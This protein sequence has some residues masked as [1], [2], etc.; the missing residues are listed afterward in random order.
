M[1]L[2]GLC[3]VG[4]P[5][6]LTVSLVLQMHPRARDGA[7]VSQQG[8]APG[9]LRRPRTQAGGHRAAQRGAAGPQPAPQA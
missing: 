3:E 1:Q 2:D 6:R 7:Q 8:S 4:L 5:L 9:S